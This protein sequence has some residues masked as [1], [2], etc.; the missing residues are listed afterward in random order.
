[1]SETYAEQ[2][3]RVRGMADGGDTWDLSDNDTAALTAM[4][5]RLEH[6]ETR[7]MVCSYCGKGSSPGTPEEKQRE[8]LA[9]VLACE[10]RPE[11]RMA[12]T[13]HSICITLGLDTWD[14]LPQ[15]DSAALLESVERALNARTLAAF[16]RG[17]RASRAADGQDPDGFGDKSE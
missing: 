12:A 5:S 11:A 8:A 4:L 1:M 7:D 17:L 6:L 13:L 2:L 14:D 9:H 10:K 16:L 15:G 3:D